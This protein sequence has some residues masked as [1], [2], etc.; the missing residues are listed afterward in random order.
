V[1]HAVADGHHEPELLDQRQERG[2]RQQASGGVAPAQQRLRTDDPA[3]VQ[4]D[5]GLVEQDELVALQG[6]LE[7]GFEGEPLHGVVAHGRLEQPPA[8][9]ALTFGVVHRDVGVA[10]QVLGELVAGL[11]LRRADRDADAGPHRQ[12][13]ALDQDRLGQ[14]V[15]HA[16]GDGDGLRRHREP[17]EQD[18][19]LVPAEP[20]D[21]V[22][23]ADAVEQALGDHHEQP[24]AGVVAERVVDRLEAVEVEQEHGEPAGGRLAGPGHGPFQP[25]REHRAVR[26]P[27]ERVMERLMGQLAP[28]AVAL[29]Q[30]LAQAPAHD[31][32]EQQAG[33]G[34]RER[35]ERE[36]ATAQDHQRAR[37]QGQPEYREAG[38]RQVRG[39]WRGGSGQL[40][41]RRVQGRQPE[42]PEVEDERPFHPARV[43]RRAL[44]DHDDLA[45]A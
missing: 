17:V 37:D 14:A 1:E 13:P 9:G 24:V 22:A 27:G 28:A 41:H 39:V 26:Q 4:L 42:T 34:G 36:A 12:L 19:E 11:R 25:R 33:D 3:A 23:R 15:Q 45:D 8:V 21:Q 16:L 40:H 43:G 30:E 32:R 29:G 35:G 20:G 18:H 38:E 6:V 44:P 5:D 10:Q 31:Q 2:G 7:V